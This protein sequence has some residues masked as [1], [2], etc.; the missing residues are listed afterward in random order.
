MPDQAMLWGRVLA[1]SILA[2]TIAYYRFV[3]AFLNYR[4]NLRV[5]FGY[6][7]LGAF[8]VAAALGHIPR[9]VT[10]P[11]TD[12]GLFVLDRGPLLYPLAVIAVA[13]VVMAIMALIRRRRALTSSLERNRISYLM[14]G[15]AA[16][17]LFALTNMSDS[18]S[19]YSIDHLGNVLNSCL[20]GYAIMRHKLLEVS[21]VIRRGLAYSMSTLP[22]TALYFFSLFMVQ[23]LFQDWQTGNQIL[24][25]SVTAIIAAVLHRPVTNNVNKIVDRLF[26]GKSYDY[27]QR[28]A[29][30]STDMGHVLDLEELAQSL[31][32]LTTKAVG[33]SQA[34][35]MLPSRGGYAVQFGCNSQ[36]GEPISF[37]K[38]DRDN[39]LIAWLE[40][41]RR[42][43]T[44]DSADVSAE[45]Q[46]LWE[47]ESRALDAMGCELLCPV[48]SGGQL[49]GLLVL[50]K[51]EDGGTYSSED[52]GLLMS[53][54][55][56]VAV[57]V[58]NAQR[59]AAVKVEA[60]TDDLTTLFNHRVFHDRLEQEI[61]RSSRFGLNFSLLMIDIDLF[62]TYNDAYGHLAG[63]TV[64]R[65][66]AE[67]INISKRHT[68]LAFRYGGE[69]FTVILPE[70]NAREAYK[71]AER[72]RRT[73]EAKME[74]FGIL[75]TISIG[76]AS[77]PQDAVMAA[78]MIKAADAALFYAKQ[79]GRN[80][81]QLAAQI[82]TSD[83]SRVG[84]VDGRPSTLSLVYALAATVDAKD[85]YTYGHSKK[86]SKYAGL[87]GEIMG[88]S[89]SR[90]ASLRN[91]GLLHD[92]GK[93]GVADAVLRKPGR[94]D[95]EEW[96][97]IRTHPELG[98]TIMR[99]VDQLEGC[100]PAIRHHHEHLDGS[101]YPLGLQGEAI[102]LE[103]RILSVADAYDA[104]TSARPYR[105]PLP[106]ELA[107]DELLRNA[108]TQFDPRVVEAFVSLETRSPLWTPEPRSTPA[109]DPALESVAGAS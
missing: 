104:M 94:L 3:L 55:R 40:R 95:K 50:G 108:G 7:V 51:K 76:V 34:G 73:V 106:P 59:H 102:P 67:C 15:M 27:R 37:L 96:Q 62:R 53:L 89:Q 82:L 17:T 25:L 43:L 68:D 83:L 8:V 90:V 16:L 63:D 49:V 57:L 32:Q 100:L 19:V 5:Y 22:L 70:A 66:I 2:L 42:P 52:L 86:V 45:L 48:M 72:I 103:A 44:R 41:E 60:N 69:E 1:L 28:L 77:W 109:P 80:C 47:D 14:V 26:M 97:Q 11:D 61:S 107:L 99:H 31:L 88:L 9:S 92:I 4:P 79:M 84:W 33:A 21:I 12:D 75:L 13:Y 24:A 30:F 56:D 58:E 29:T 6:A 91:S 54:G 71:V 85:H 23:K 87:I 78:E 64:L 98:V 10:L 105:D 39:P 35:L 65:K 46:S 18:L 93:I 81:T 20:I 74:N 38:L 101:G 36:P